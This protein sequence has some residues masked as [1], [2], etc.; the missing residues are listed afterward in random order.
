MRR[1]ILRQEKGG[2]KGLKAKEQVC[3]G[4]RPTS[5]ISSAL[6]QS[7]RSLCQ[8][9]VISG[10]G[11]IAKVP[12]PCGSQWLSYGLYLFT[13]GV[14]V[15]SGNQAFPGKSG[16]CISWRHPAIHRSS[17]RLSGC[18]APLQPATS[19]VLG[20]EVIN[21]VSEGLWLW[22]NEGE[23]ACPFQSSHKPPGPLPES[24]VILQGS[25]KMPIDHWPLKLLPE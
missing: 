12:N 25:Q 16:G 18:P 14:P 9:N 13:E 21:G 7:V 24:T 1:A 11:S 15:G 2:I 10:V 4:R 3:M 6:G 20:A 8:I 19:L 5:G 17:L 23:T 22:S